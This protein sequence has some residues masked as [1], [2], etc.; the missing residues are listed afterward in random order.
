MDL[1]AAEPYVKP[2]VR[3]R[4]AKELP[5][6]TLCP[7]AEVQKSIRS[8]WIHPH[9]ECL[10]VC[11]RLTCKAGASLSDRWGEGTVLQPQ[12]QPMLSRVYGVDRQGVQ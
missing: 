3:G 8:A 11:T 5:L 1:A 7:K 9:T 12:G 6:P 10:L 2:G 4:S